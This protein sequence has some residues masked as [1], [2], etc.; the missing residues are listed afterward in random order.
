[1]SLTRS[2]IDI[3]LTGV[4]TQ[5]RLANVAFSGH[6]CEYVDSHKNIPSRI[7]ENNYIHSRRARPEV[8]FVMSGAT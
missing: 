4:L 7:K 5:T 3:I 6:I 1:M 2:E 8:H